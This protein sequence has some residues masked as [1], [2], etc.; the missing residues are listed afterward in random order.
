MQTN[1]VAERAAVG[2]AEE[3]LALVD[4]GN[5][6]E[7][8]QHAASLFK[9]GISSERFFISGISNQQWRSSVKEVQASLGKV[10]LRRLKS[11]RYTEEL[12]WEPDGEYVVIEYE[13]SFER[14]MNRT[15]VVILIKERDGVWRVC[16][17]K[18]KIGT[19]NKALDPTRNQRAS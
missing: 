4:A 8:W 1:E 16:R 14:Q 12:P 17:Y 5:S 11:K 2:A 18:F 6:E 10:A 7:S 9:Y 19:S 15:E 3:W 13:T